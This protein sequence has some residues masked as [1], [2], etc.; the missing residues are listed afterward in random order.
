MT[1][2]THT[3]PKCVNNFDLTSNLKNIIYTIE[4]HTHTKPVVFIFIERCNIFRISILRKGGGGTSLLLYAHA[5]KCLYRLYL[6]TND[7]IYV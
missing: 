7:E 4:L 1:F 3:S 2:Y 6:H 5:Y